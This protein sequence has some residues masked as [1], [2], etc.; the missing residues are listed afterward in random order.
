ME[1]NNIKKGSNISYILLVIAL[2]IIIGLLSFLVYKAYSDKNNGNNNGSNSSEVSNEVTDADKKTDN[3]QQ[4][5]KLTDDEKKE[6]LDIIGLTENGINKEDSAGHKTT[7]YY[8]FQ[9]VMRRL[10][11]TGTFKIDDL[12]VD[13][14]EEIILTYALDK[15]LVGQVLG[16]DYANCEAGA[17]WCTSVAFDDYAKIAKVLNIKTNPKTIFGDRVYNN[18]YLFTYGGSVAFDLEVTDKVSLKEESDNVKVIY[19]I[20]ATYQ[21]VNGDGSKSATINRTYTYTFKKDTSNNYY[22]DTINIKNN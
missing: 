4:I 15:T 13:T 2:L 20:K 5:I 1:E 7:D 17:G 21:G 9:Y 19:D 22:L 12:P 14:I 3:N 10:N 16:E 18:N 6:L 8:S 11:K